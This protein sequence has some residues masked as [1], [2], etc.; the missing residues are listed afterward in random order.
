MTTGWIVA[1]AIA[2]APAQQVVQPSQGE[3]FAN[4]LRLDS[5][6]QAPVVQQILTEAQKEAAPVLQ[7]LLQIR[8]E[9]LNLALAGK[10]A[11]LAA[12]GD[13]YAVAAASMAAIEAQAFARVHETLRDN[14]KSRAADAFNLMGGLFLPPAHLISVAP[15]PGGGGGEGRGRGGN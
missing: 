10:P 15:G 2:L 12:A 3:I 1:L 5:R 11:E 6:S 8:E 13:R 4:R 7:Q 14:Q 9:M